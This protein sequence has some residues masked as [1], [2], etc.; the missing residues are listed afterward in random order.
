MLPHI[1]HQRKTPVL[2][3]IHFNPNIQSVT[4]VAPDHKIGNILD[5]CLATK[6]KKHCWW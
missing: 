1:L 2:L 4:F 6:G 5:L 3:K